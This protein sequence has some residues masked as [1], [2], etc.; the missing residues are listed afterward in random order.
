MLRVIINADDLGASQQ[1]NDAIE[2]CIKKG[3]ITS[4][5]II[6]SGESLKDASR[7]AKVY[8]GTISFGVHLTLDEF[9][10]I[11]HS[12]ILYRYGLTD[13]TGR[14][15]KNGYKK[16]SRYSEELLTA[17][18]EEW[19]AQIKKIKTEGI[20]IS[21]ADGHHHCH[22]YFQL[23]GVL[24]EVLRANG[25]NKVRLPQSRTFYMRVKGINRPSIKNNTQ[26]AYMKGSKK[27][28]F[29]RA[30]MGSFKDYWTLSWYKTHF[31]TVDFFSS[32]SFMQTHKA[33]LKE[34]YPNYT[35]EL[36]CHPGHPNYEEETVA[37][38][39]MCEDCS[40]INYCQL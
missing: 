32:A 8:K 27:T 7:I 24:L 10:S 23:K 28:S 39:G 33:F 19:D 1:V 38:N 15:V 11:T 6:A 17:I 36:M 40:K 31:K 14:F 5:T 18:R 21:H 29:L 9:D 4:T 35:V 25:I 13:N 2:S 20:D 16:V 3:T 30:V 37:L 22:T 34:Y 12:P 26:L